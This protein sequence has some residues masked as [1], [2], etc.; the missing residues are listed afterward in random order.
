MQSKDFAMSIYSFQRQMSRKIVKHLKIRQN[1]VAY[2]F[3][4]Y[5]NMIL[6]GLTEK[7]YKELCHFFGHTILLLIRAQTLPIV[8]LSKRDADYFW[9]KL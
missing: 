5:W 6:T 1:M 4:I 3:S 8:F 9:W 2:P 7:F